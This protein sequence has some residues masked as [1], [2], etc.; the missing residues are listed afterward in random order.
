[1][2]TN[3]TSLAQY[4]FS[5]CYILVSKKSTITVNVVL[6]VSV[7]AGGLH[8]GRLQQPVVRGDVLDAGGVRAGRVHV[9]A[10]LLPAPRRRAAGGRGARHGE[11]RL[12]AGG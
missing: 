7:L 5:I 3:L 11:W 6:S 4:L 12:V 8:G 9:R 2:I 1:M 10:A